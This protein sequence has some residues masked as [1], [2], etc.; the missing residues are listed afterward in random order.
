SNA[1]GAPRRREMPRARPRGRAGGLLLAGAAAAWSAGRAPFVAPGAPR[2]GGRP[3]RTA[4]AAPDPPWRRDVPTYFS[5]RK[6]SWRRGFGSGV[7]W[8]GAMA[9]DAQRGEELAD[10]LRQASIETLADYGA[11]AEGYA[12]G[13]ANHDVSQNVNALLRALE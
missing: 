5:P 9:D 8:E 3:P 6:K 10:A 11:V 2:R 13:N 4:A 12:A 7:G 1:P